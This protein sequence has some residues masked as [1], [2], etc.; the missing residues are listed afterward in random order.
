[1]A[2]FPKLKTGVVAQY[3]ATKEYRFSTVSRRFVDGTEQRHRD[4]SGGRLRWAVNLSRLDGA[5]I[6]EVEEFF[7][8]QQGRLGSFDFEDPW[9]QTVIANCHFGQDVLSVLADGE[10]DNRTELLIVGPRT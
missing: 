4:A 9:T 8:I 3:P 1:M 6:A 5:E 2:E 10:F 7:R